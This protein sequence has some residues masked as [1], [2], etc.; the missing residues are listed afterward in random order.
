MVAPLIN[1]EGE[2]V[3]LIKYQS[4]ALRLRIN[5]EVHDI[6]EPQIDAKKNNTIE[7]VVD[8]FT[9]K[10]DIENRLSESLETTLDLSNGI[11]KI[12]SLDDSSLDILFSNKFACPECGYSIPELEPR[13][14]SFN[15]PAGACE[16]VMD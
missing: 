16:N 12:I 4:R 11:A 10:P 15:N 14:F 3:D 7:V 6:D 2:H 13:T 9:I 5:G 8:R 1:N